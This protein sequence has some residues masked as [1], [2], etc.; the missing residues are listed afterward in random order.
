MK[1][2]LDLNAEFDKISE[3]QAELDKNPVPIVVDR[4]DPRGILSAER[5]IA[6]RQDTR[7]SQ[8]GK[9]VVLLG[10][11]IVRL[12]RTSSRLAIVNIILTVVVVL[13]GVLQVVLMIRGH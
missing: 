9:S 1:E 7:E 3:S 11:A 5:S 12:D 6:A 13:I 10:K 2:K 4:V 8:L